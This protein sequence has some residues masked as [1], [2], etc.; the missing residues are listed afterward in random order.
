[1]SAWYGGL[2]PGLLTMVVAGL[3]ADYLF[4]YSG[5]YSSGFGPEA[6]SLPVFSKRNGPGER[7]GLSGMRERVSLLGGRFELHSEPG[8]GTTVEAE[9]DLPE[10][11]TDH[12]G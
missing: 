4:L 9:V 3:A 5:G 10:E 2:G 8:A 6:A 1:V 11:D 12:E 7:I